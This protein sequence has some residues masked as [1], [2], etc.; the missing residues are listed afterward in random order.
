MLGPSVPHSQPYLSRCHC[1]VSATCASF[2]FSA[3]VLLL[4]LHTL[5]TSRLTQAVRYLN[6][7]NFPINVPSIGEQPITEETVYKMLLRATI[8]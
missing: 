4:S 3:S 8:A 2:A 7:L 1:G 6:H 5:S